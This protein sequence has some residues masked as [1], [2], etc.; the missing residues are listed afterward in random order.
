VFSKLG[1]VTVQGGKGTV[2]EFGTH[3]P[4][5]A[6]W[7]GTIK[8]GQVKDDLIDFSDVLPTVAEIGGAKLPKTTIDGKSFAHQLTSDATPARSWVFSQL[9]HKKLA[10]DQRFMLHDNGTI[11]DIAADPFE[12]KNLAD[13]KDADVIASKTR[14]E[15]VLTTL[16]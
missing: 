13:S 11:Y 3:V 5:I 10:R 16:R 12:K 7:K 2:S 15:K 14:L 9:G 4:F 1:N 6:S 8:P